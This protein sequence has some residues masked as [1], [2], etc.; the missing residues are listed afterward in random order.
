[1]SQEFTSPLVAEL[2]SNKGV[3]K[4]GDL[5]VRLAEF[6]GFCWGVERAI[7][8]AYETK[9]HFPNKKIHITNE[10]IHNPE[11]CHSFCAIIYKVTSLL[12]C[13]AGE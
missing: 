6:F 2:R 8:M 11:V 4:R 7:A 3:L 10:I 12:V 1:M 9:S 5:T 13:I